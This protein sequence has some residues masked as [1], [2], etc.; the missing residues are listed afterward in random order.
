MTEDEQLEAE[1]E[2]VSS[3][4]QPWTEVWEQAWEAY[5]SQ[6]LGGNDKAASLRNL[7]KRQND[8]RYLGGKYFSE[9]CQYLPKAKCPPIE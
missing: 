7:A 4:R 3:K 5:Q 9:V 2:K 8:A 1:I 6:K